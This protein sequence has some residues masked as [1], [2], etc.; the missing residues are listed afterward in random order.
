MKL[1]QAATVHRVL[2]TLVI[3]LLIYMGYLVLKV[4]LAP[5]VWAAILAYVTWP[6]YLRFRGWFKDSANGSAAFMTVSLT[7]MLVV[8]MLWIFFV[9]QEEVAIVYQKL[10]DSFIH[11]KVVLPAFLHNFPGISKFLQGYLDRFSNDPEAL[12][13]QWLQWSQYGVSAAGELASTVSRNLAKMGITLFTLFF[14]YRDGERIVQQIRQALG[15]LIG[16]KAHDYIHAA[17]DMTRAVVNGIV[18][19]ALAQGFLAGIGYAVAG[20]ENPVF[21]AAV[22]TLVAMVPFGTPFAWGAVSIWLFMHGH[23]VEAIGLA[24]WGAGFVSTIDNVIRPM[25]ISSATEIPFL[26]VMFG[27]LG[28]LSAFGMVGLFLGPVILAVLMAVW[29]QWLAS[30]EPTA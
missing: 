1:F 2:L 12:K 13:A 17:G 25:V 16:N 30:E 23:T 4:F 9:L 21:L 29:R 19:T 7:V 22:T 3:S 11:G 5:A 26:L 8:P 14:F 28:G 10:I 20:M 27:V 6:A 18:L 24:I 15:M